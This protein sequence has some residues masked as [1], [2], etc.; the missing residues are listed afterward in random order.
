MITMLLGGLWHGA[1]WTFVLWG[2]MHNVYLVIHHSWLKLTDRWRWRE[3]TGWYKLIG[4]VL[5]VALT[6]FF[7]AL[8]WIF[9][10][11]DSMA[12]AMAI[13][14]GCLGLNGLSVAASNGWLT[15]TGVAWFHAVGLPV[16]TEGVFELNSVM[17]DFNPGTVARL[18]LICALIIWMAPS[19]QTIATRWSR[20]T[21]AP[22]MVLRG[23]TVAF[24]L[25]VSLSH[26]GRISTFIYYQF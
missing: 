10:R 14:R 6:F 8:A 23:G 11:S 26:I 25:L 21:A 1:N 9:F 20:Q 16:V 12:S 5:S 13:L 4:S 15:Q 24:L 7:V 17:R 2:G 19:A 3:P 22:W 18:L